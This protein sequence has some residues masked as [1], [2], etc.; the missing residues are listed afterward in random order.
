MELCFLISVDGTLLSWV[1]AVS[2]LLLLWLCARGF[3][4]ETPAMASA[5]TLL[6]LAT[7]VTGVINLVNYGGRYFTYGI[8]TVIVH[9]V[10]Y[11]LVAV[12]WLCASKAK[13]GEE[14]GG[15]RMTALILSGALAA[16]ELVYCVSVLS[17]S[18]KMLFYGLGWLGF[19]AV[20]G[21]LLLKN[22]TPAAA[23]PVSAA[24]PAGP[25]GVRC[26]RCGASLP[27]GSLFCD[28]CGSS[29]PGGGEGK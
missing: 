11:A 26:P 13:K 12:I 6:V 15:L 4:A 23:A 9:L 25:D 27:K 16:Y 17:K 20:Y 28:K 8:E 21:L 3:G 5:Y 10:F 19:I 18:A 14:H 7:L 1:C 24:V 22:D 29:V 2:G